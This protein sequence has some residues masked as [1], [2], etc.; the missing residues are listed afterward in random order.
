MVT[1]HAL[2]RRIILHRVGDVAPL[3][4]SFGHH[5]V[6]NGPGLGMLTDFAQG[7]HDGE[8]GRVN[9]IAVK[10]VGD[11]NGSFV[12]NVA[13]IG[14]RNPTDTHA[15]VCVT[16]KGFNQ[17]LTQQRDAEAEN[18]FPILFAN[19][20]PVYIQ[21]HMR[22]IGIHLDFGLLLAAVDIP[23]AAQMHEGAASGQM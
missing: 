15:V 16:R 18:G 9:I 3:G 21:L 10:P 8:T 23:L 22:L 17:V 2:Q 13:L 6:H 12:E 4:C 7:V 20:R 19:E 11:G 14:L 1:H 5:L